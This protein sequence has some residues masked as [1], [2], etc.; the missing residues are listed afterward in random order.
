[1]P[2]IITL[3]TDFGTRDGYIGAVKGVLY[4]GA[5]S[6]QIVD[7]THDIEPFNVHQAAFT[8]LNYYDRFPKDTIHIVVVDPGVGTSRRGLVIR[9]PE[10]YLVGPDNGVFS[11]I[12]PRAGFR[13]YK[14]QESKL[15]REV[16]PTFHGRDV[17]APAALKILGKEDINSF[18]EPVYDLQSFEKKYEKKADGSYRLEV[19]HVDRFGNLILNYTRYDW[20]RMGSSEKIKLHFARGFLYGLKDTF[21]AAKEKEVLCMWDSSGFLQIAQNRG[22]AADTLQMG[23]GDE[24][25]ISFDRLTSNKKAH[26]V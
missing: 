5:P 2:G 11:L 26:S 14:I 7:I 22:N 12:F 4:S 21:G 19:I 1:M 25:R 8:L 23:V 16:S 18:A 13:A 6:A 24:V 15:G 10:H 9:T 3:M 17:F 20:E